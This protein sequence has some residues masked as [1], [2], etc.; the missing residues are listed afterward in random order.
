VTV[1][2]HHVVDGPDD[3]PVLVMAGSLGSSGEMWRP[4]V[5]A[6]ADRFRVI[7]VD[8]RG[9][10][11]SPSTPGEYR[12]ADL[13]DDVRALLDRLD[14]ERVD[15]CGLSIGAMVGMHLASETP[16]RIGRLVLC[17]TSA[18]FPDPSAYVERIAAVAAGGTGSI[19]QD[20]V[21]RWF[22]PGWA[23]EHPDEVARA[24]AMVAGTSDEGY[25]GCCAALA[26][27]DHRD[28]LGAIAA[29]TLV[30]AGADDPATPVEP[31]ARTLA[32]GIPGA[33]L[34][35]VPGAHLAT[36]ESAPAVNALLVDHLGR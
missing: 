35:V 5:P 32:E 20:V 14:L 10:G 31:H 9:H 6:L 33:E 2:L 4:Q 29:P 11:G 16:E 25:A 19:A 27:W 3:G 26:A 34:K 7:R 13:A 28:R 12:L 30:V 23:A 22:T 1:A 15:W 17:C 21:A 8:L 18:W 24:E 36:I